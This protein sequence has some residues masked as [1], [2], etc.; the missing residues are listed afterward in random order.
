MITRTQ[1]PQRIKDEEP[2]FMKDYSSLR[3]F[4]LGDNTFAVQQPCVTVVVLNWNGWRDTISC[5]ESVFKSD[6]KNYRLIILDNGSEDDSVVEISRWLKSRSGN[7]DCVA[8]QGTFDGVDV[9]CQASSVALLASNDNCG[10][11]EGCNLTIKY[12]LENYHPDYFFFLNNDAL[13]D[14]MCLTKCIESAEK[15]AAIV[16]STIM[17]ADGASILFMGGSRRRELFFASKPRL[18]NNLHDEYATGRVEGS[19]MLVSARFAEKQLKHLG[20]VFDPSFF[21][22]GEETDLCFRAG[23]SGNRVVM[24]RDAV[25]YHGLAQSSGGGG[26]PLQYYYTTRNRIYLANR[27]LP[28]PVKILFHMYYSPSRL[29]RVI[30]LLFR[31][32]AVVAGAILEGLVDGYRGKFGKWKRH[33]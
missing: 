7:I 4:D 24:R 28:F 30:Q 18:M 19:G 26:N 32:K 17:S 25:V 11:A 31:K 10:F 9:I 2:F 27:W 15:G 22:Y 1:K 16:G 5:L 23:S 8:K 6:Y 12:S 33:E 21:L 13:M 14:K 20:Y 29:I 3:T